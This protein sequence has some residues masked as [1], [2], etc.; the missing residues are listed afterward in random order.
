MVTLQWG[1]AIGYDI[2]AFD[3]RG[4]VAFLEVKSTASHRRAWILQKKFAHPENDPIP[5]A[6]RFVCCVDLTVSDTA[7]NVYVFPAQVVA[8]GLHYF[9]GGR[10]SRSPSYTLR[11]DEKPRGRTRDAS[12]VTV[13]AH[14]EAQ[15]YLEAFNTLGITAVLK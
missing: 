1:T 6:R 13:G 12:A 14:I 11:L 8:R 5:V 15:R 3:K 9:Y 7:P 2:L 10:F 4:T